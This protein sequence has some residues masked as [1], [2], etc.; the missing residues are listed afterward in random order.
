MKQQ[1][2][3]WSPWSWVVVNGLR[4][5]SFPFPQLVS[6]SGAQDAH[7]FCLSHVYTTCEVPGMGCL[8]FDI[9]KTVYEGSLPPPGLTGEP[10]AQ[11]C[12]LDVWDCFLGRGAQLRSKAETLG[13]V[14]F[15]LE[16][17]GGVSGDVAVVQLL[18]PTL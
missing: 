12:S 4:A 14:N 16:S 2:G 18:S 1:P 10:D 11:V 17:P 8:V 9:W 6:P 7:G 15:L 5:L 3:L 13:T